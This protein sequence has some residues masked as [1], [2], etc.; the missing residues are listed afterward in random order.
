MA[1][2]MERDIIIC[3]RMRTPNAYVGTNS[4]EIPG[5]AY[6]QELFSKKERDFAA[7]LQDCVL[8][9]AKAGKLTSQRSDW[10]S[11][12][13]RQKQEATREIFT[14]ALSRRLAAVNEK[15][16]KRRRLV[17]SEVRKLS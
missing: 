15:K 10:L 3:C 12:E 5:D 11:N 6:L 8:N 16:A 13:L 9:V 7:L 1:V 17:E 2:K 4:T 14:G